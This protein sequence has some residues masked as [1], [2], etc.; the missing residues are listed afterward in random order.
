MQAVTIEAAVESKDVP[1]GTARRQVVEQLT[2]GR[3]R[4]TR[5]EAWSSVAFRSLAVAQGLA[6]G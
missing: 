6:G 1:G 5:I 2:Q 4:L 3:E